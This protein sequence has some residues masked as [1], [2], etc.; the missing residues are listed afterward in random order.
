MT[1]ADSPPAEARCGQ[2]S[3]ARRVNRRNMTR[4]PGAIPFADDACLGS[5]SHDY[6]AEPDPH[7]L[8]RAT[9][10]QCERIERDRENLVPLGVRRSS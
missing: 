7:V 3:M 2:R 9:G 5:D 10:E 8:R 6:L 1:L 4:W